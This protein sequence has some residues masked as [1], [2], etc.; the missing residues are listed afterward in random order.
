[1]SVVSHGRRIIS[2]AERRKSAKKWQKTETGKRFCGKQQW[3]SVTKMKN[4]I[5]FLSH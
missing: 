5:N 2:M 3:R 1:M 4:F